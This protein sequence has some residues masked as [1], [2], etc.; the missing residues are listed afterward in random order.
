[1][2]PRYVYT[3]AAPQPAGHYS[4]VIIYDGIAYISG[5]LPIDPRA[6]KI[7]ALDFE[8]QASQALNN[9]EAILKAAGS[10]MSHVLKTTVYIPDVSYWS[11]ANEQY[12]K[13]FGKS[14]PAR[15]IV[16]TRELHRGA[17][18]EIDAIAAIIKPIT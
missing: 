18:I 1:M 5:Q 7:L 16:P 6:G 8:G 13:S 10:D 9:L 17:L 4:Q 3:K 12:A 2:E 14:R 15:T 11:R